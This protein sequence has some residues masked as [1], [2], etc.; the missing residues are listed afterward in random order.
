MI[1]E[2]KP[3]DKPAEYFT[4]ES[5]LMRFCIARKFKYKDILKM[6]TE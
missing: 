6:W 4:N 3:E 1:H 5:T 2:Y